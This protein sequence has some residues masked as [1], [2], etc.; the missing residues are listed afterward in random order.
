[1]QEGASIWYFF[2]Q[3]QHSGLQS[4]I[5]A[6]KAQEMTGIMLTYLMVDNHLSTAVSQLPDYIANIRNVSG[7]GTVTNGDVQA[8]GIYNADGSINTGHIPDWRTLSSAD[9]DKLITEQRR[10][11]IKKGTGRENAN[12]SGGGIGS[13]AGNNANRI[14][15]YQK[16]NE[17]YKRQINA[18]K[19]SDSDSTSV[20]TDYDSVASDAG[21]IF[22]GKRRRRRIRTDF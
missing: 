10:L 8:N 7:V 1:M 3:I 14:K 4:S 9:R 6:L 21:D 2:N 19:R 17:K 15:R 18:L 16:Q 20:A 22:G 5:E 11:S 13:N 12:H